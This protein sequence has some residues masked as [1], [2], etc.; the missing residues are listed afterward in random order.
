MVHFR[1]GGVQQL[2]VTAGATAVGVVP[3]DEVIDFSKSSQKHSLKPQQ[4][5]TR[6]V[7]SLMHFDSWTFVGHDMMVIASAIATFDADAEVSFIAK[8]HIYTPKN[9]GLLSDLHIW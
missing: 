3:P 2:A 1:N 4:E 9:H 6:A 7:I 8:I 5:S